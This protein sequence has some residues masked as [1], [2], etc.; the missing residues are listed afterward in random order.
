[1][2]I[3]AKFLLT[4]VL[5]VFF[6]VIILNFVNLGLNKA[7][8][9]TADGEIIHAIQDDLTHTTNGITTLITA[10]DE[11]VQKTVKDN[12]N[13][14]G[15]FI[16]QNGPI[17]L[18][19][20]T[21]QWEAV[22]QVDQTS[23][24]I[25]LPMLSTGDKLLEKNEA[26]D[27][28][29]YIVDEIT[30]LVGGTATI[31]QRMNEMG[32]MLRVSTTILKADGKRAI[33]TYIPAKNPDGSF[34]PVIEKLL[35]GESYFG[36]AFVVDKWY[37]TAYHPLFNENKEVI[38]AYYVGVEQQ[39]IEALRKGISS[40]IIGK[41]GYIFIMNGQGDDQGTYVI[42]KGGKQDGQNISNLQDINGNYIIQDMIST[43]MS[44]SDENNKF[45]RYQWLDEGQ[46]IPRWKTVKLTYYEPWDWVIGASAY[47][48]EISSYKT[49]MDMNSKH[50]VW[51]YSLTGIIVMLISGF[52]IWRFSNRISQTINKVSNAIGK[53]AAE[54][55]PA[56]M[57]SMQAAEKG[58]L[59]SQLIL[60][61]SPIQVKTGDE[62]ETMA[63]SYNEIAAIVEKV[64]VSYNQMLS[65][66]DHSMFALLQHAKGVSQSSQIL[67]ETSQQSEM[68]TAQVTQTIQQIA[69]STSSLAEN[70]NS[71]VCTI[72]ML[73]QSISTVTQ[74]ATDQITALGQANQFA[75]QMQE[76]VSE[77]NRSASE[78]GVVVQRTIEQAKDGADSMD[79][80]ISG[81]QQI[82]KKV[83]ESRAA[84]L[85]MHEQSMAINKITDTIQEIAS[86]TNLLALNAAIE[87]ARAGE[88]G[89]GF[90]VVADE[91][92]KLAEHSTKATKEIDQVVKILQNTIQRVTD[93][94]DESNQYVIG[95]VTLVNASGIAL[96]S[97]M[98]AIQTVSSQSSQSELLTNQI[99][100][101]SQQMLIALQ[102]TASISE[103]NHI[104]AQQ[105][106]SQANQV[107]QTT[108]DIAAIS[109]ENGAAVE[110]V[111]A[112]AKELTTQAQDVAKS[113]EELLH[114]AN[115]MENNLAKFTLSNNSQ[116]PQD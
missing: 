77:I 74:G 99:S 21:M 44:K 54:D 40:T 31:F 110:E 104:A 11:S 34:N 106:N 76:K 5:S 36:T 17:T 42:S 46:T 13:V 86:Q 94:M 58:N 48:D 56:L 107:L 57:L 72:E 16:E 80:T 69:I 109:E 111:S 30:S 116:S 50:M 91:V 75:E 61:A 98:E 4:G 64:A 79:K 65:K 3:R 43:A 84:V 60:H 39:N 73:H 7:L 112:S 45:I 2:S 70:T 29:S 8:I 62:L 97:I 63:N 113:A 14:A 87:A 114:M 35:Q 88:A 52:F 92:R 10:I 27:Q 25:I 47:E 66:L 23:L 24:S 22:N 1:M 78:V 55:F 59:T 101:N 41:T 67:L 103:E 53:M 89:K 33:G 82:E 32:D 20:K 90:A 12:L 81:M 83:F 96:Q 19:D 18:S 108:S 15:Y 93:S 100:E 68:A 105:V 9:E 6:T 85:T 38:G 71:T 115:E 49:V 37:V 51:G 26:A 102:A 28:E 95:G